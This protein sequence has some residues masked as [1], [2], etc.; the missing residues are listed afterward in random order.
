LSR[1]S[2]STLLRREGFHCVT[3]KDGVA[4]REK[5]R[6]Q[7]FDCLI[8]DIRMLG[9]TEVELIKTSTVLHPDMPVILITG[10]PN[11]ETV[12]ASF[13]L[14]VFCYLTKPVDFRSLLTAVRNAVCR[15]RTLGEMD[16]MRGRLVQCLTRIG[17][18]S[19]DLREC[20]RLS[21]EK[22][23]RTFIKECNTYAET[24]K[25]RLEPLWRQITGELQRS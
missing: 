6:T 15:R 22:A 12:S 1:L 8:S 24:T 13:R 2:I 21:G 9:N 19:S 3:E 7:Q 14:P 4:A 16:A 10:Y 5:L 11:E 17:Q 20:K 18:L 25:A 23:A